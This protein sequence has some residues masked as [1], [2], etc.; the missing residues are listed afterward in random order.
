MAIPATTKTPTS[1]KT[2]D[3]L[4][5]PLTRGRLWLRR[6]LEPV[7]G[8]RVRGDV[9]EAVEQLGLLRG[10]TGADAGRAVLG[11]EPGEG[12][13]GDRRQRWGARQAR[14]G[15]VHAGVVVPAV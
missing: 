4:N 14:L 13:S 3:R 12:G 15:A 6:R 8:L 5:S 1:P 2:A 7:A 10:A 11:K 9:R